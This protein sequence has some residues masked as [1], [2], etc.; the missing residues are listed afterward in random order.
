MNLDDV[1]NLAI[2]FLAVMA[3]A[4]L[5][6]AFMLALAVRRLRSL[7]IP[8]DATFTET[9]FLT[10]VSLVIAIDL[11]DLALDVLAVPISW[12]VL[13]RLGL[14]ALR[15][16]AAVEALIPGTQFLPTLTACWFGVRLLRRPVGNLKNDRV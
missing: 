3:F 13:D 16:V 14:K 5:T 9:L 2:A 11:L 10:P 4:G 8:P 6:G 7:E 1:R 12:A 15:G